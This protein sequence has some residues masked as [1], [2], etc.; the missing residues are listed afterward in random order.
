MRDTVYT[1]MPNILEIRLDSQL[2]YLHRRDSATITYKVSTGTERLDRGIKTRKGIFVVQN[3]I[4]WLY[5]IQF[6]STKVFNWLGYNYGIG[7]HSLAGRGYFR[8]LGRRPSSHGCVRVG[9]N[10]AKAIFDVVEIGT[11][12]MVHSGD[13]ARTVAFLPPETEI[14][15]ASRTKQE[16][17]DI[18]ATCLRDLYKGEKLFR[19]HPIVPLDRQYIGH[20]GIPIGTMEKV[21]AH[22]KVP[23]VSNMNYT[24]V[25][26][27]TRIPEPKLKRW[28]GESEAVEKAAVEQ[29][30][31]P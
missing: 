17:L 11:P 8:H 14:D 5:S 6:D 3:K 1:R 27:R 9:P 18:Y 19:R 25:P 16:V 10:D 22:Q 7:F 29:T 23:S 28:T 24:A 20:E 4:K 12:V 2:V 31:L 21:P 26:L 13:Y 30:I 15:T